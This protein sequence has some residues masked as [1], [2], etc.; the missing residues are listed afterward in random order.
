MAERCAVIGIGQTKHDAKRG[1]VSMAGLCARRLDARSTTPA[2]DWRDIDAVVIGKAPDMFEGIDDARALPRRRARRGRQADDARA[3]GRQ[4][5]RLDGDRRGAARPV[6]HPRARADRRLREADGKRTRRG[7]SR[8]AFRS[9]WRS[10]RGR[11]LLRAAHPRLHAPLGGARGHRHPGGGEG[12]PERAEESVR[13]SASAG[14]HLEMVADS[15][16]LWD[17]IRYLETCPSSDGACAM[18]LASEQRAKNGPTQA[19]V[20]PRDGDAQ[21]A[22]ACSPAATR[23]T[24]E[25]GRD[26]AADLYKKAGITQPPQGDRLRRDLRAVLAGSSRCGW[27]TS[28]SRRRAKA[29]R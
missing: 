19:G 11:R 4:R 16:M 24:R 12:P 28:A 27:R 3:Y 5:R 29:G 20:D 2:S 9:S 25:P 22:H 1:D 18:V 6:G 10:S 17:P 21:R 8:S 26:C 13:A 23:S 14:H 15:P 7:R